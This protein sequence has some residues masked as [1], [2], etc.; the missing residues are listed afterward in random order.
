M[1][2]IELGCGEST[3]HDSD[4][5]RWCLAFRTERFGTRCV[6]ALFDKELCDEYGALSGQGRLMRLPECKILTR[7]PTD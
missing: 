1:P 5:Q 7:G 6:C 2:K 4:T 3:C